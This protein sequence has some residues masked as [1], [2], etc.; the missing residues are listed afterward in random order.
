MSSKDRQ[1]LE[2]VA[3]A[4]KDLLPE[5]VFVGGVTASIYI[6]DEVAPEITPT[7]D[8]DL[9]VNITS[10]LEY[11]VLE[12]RLRKLGFKRNLAEPGPLCRFEY[13]G[14]KVDVMPLDE[15]ILGFS[16]PWYKSGFTNAV[17]IKVGALD[18][19]VLS[20][21]YFLATKFTA[22]NDRGQKGQLWESKDIEDIVVV[23][24]G[25]LHLEKD[26]REMSP[27]LLAFLQKNISALLKKG[28]LFQE[29]IHAS[30][31]DYG[32]DIARTKA[33]LLIKKLKKVTSA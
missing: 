19:K 22:F 32:H 23:L 7:E 6:E 28:D 5:V 12:K 16:N 31:T 1:V 20:L 14:I 15:K 4:L 24:N 21:P 9:I 8:V 26:F 18:V 27:D 13:N 11:E 25:R 17:S 33:L 2:L 10:R 3:K 30:L 29:A